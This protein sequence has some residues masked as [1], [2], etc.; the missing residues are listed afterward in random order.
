VKTQFHHL[1]TNPP[2]FWM[3]LATACCLK[4]VFNSFRV[5]LI[6]GVMMEHITIPTLCK[7]EGIVNILILLT[8]S[9]HQQFVL[10]LL[11]LDVIELHIE[12]YNGRRH[13]DVYGCPD[14]I[15]RHLVYVLKLFCC[16]LKYAH[17]LINILSLDGLD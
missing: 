3:S 14:D 13:R 4:D 6:P 11:L 8:T 16:S 15:I 5:E 2:I 9:L 12:Y 1:G 7:S 17:N 10:F